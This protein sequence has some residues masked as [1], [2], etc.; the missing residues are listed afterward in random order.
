MLYRSEEMEARALM[1]VAAQMCAAARTAPKATGKD[2]IYT[3]VLTREE[4]ELLAKKMEEISERD[5]IGKGRLWYQRDA[6]NLRTA[7]AVVLIG[8]KRT[9]RG[10]KNCGYCGFK[11]CGEC[12]EAGGLCAFVPLDLGI[13][14]SSA[15]CAAADARVDNRVMMSIGKAAEEMQYIK[16][17]ILWQG[18]PLSVMGKNVF[19]DRGNEHDGK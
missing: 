9:C 17:D 10:V 4:K 8:A 15:L 7:Q 3:L 14:I 1:Q 5:F 12:M 11:D 6:G 16:E 18:I 13:A 2:I 19:F